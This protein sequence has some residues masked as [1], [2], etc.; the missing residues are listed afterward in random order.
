MYQPHLPH[1]HPCWLQIHEPHL[2]APMQCLQSFLHWR[3]PPL[4]LWPHEWTPFHHYSFELRP[5]SCHSYP[6]PPN[7]FSRLLVCQHYTQTTWFHPWPHLPPVWNRIPTCSS[8]SS[9]S[10]P[11]HLLNPHFHPRPERHLQLLVSLNYST[12]DEEH[13][14]FVRKLH[15]YIF[16]ASSLRLMTLTCGPNDANHLS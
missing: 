8:I 6:I 4:S 7:S 5:T 2:P 12:A 9:H 15:Y 16:F 14:V 13:C 10:R 3:N 1:N 11:K